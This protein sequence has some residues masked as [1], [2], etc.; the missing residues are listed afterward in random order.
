MTQALESFAHRDV[1]KMCPGQSPRFP[2]HGG[3][4]PEDHKYVEF[5]SCVH[6]HCQYHHVH[7]VEGSV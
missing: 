4:I 3:R 2:V 6:C 1:R 5:D 7:D